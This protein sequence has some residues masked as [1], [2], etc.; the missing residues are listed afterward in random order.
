MD[1]LKSLYPLVRDIISRE[2]PDYWPGLR[3]VLYGL[4]G[5]PMIPEAILPLASCKAVNGEAKEAV[6]ISAAIVAAATCLRIFDDVE[7]KDRPGKL[8]CDVGPARAWNYAS[9]MQILSFNILSKAPLTPEVFHKVNRCFIDTFLHITCGQERDLSGNTRTIKDYWL[10][11]EWKIACGYATACAVGAMVGTINAELIQACRSFGHHL[12]IAIQILNDMQ[13]IW[14]SDGITDLKQGKVTLP[15]LYGLSIDHPERDELNFLMTTSE[16]STHGE[17][18]KDILDHL[19]TRSF[20][21]WA[22]LMERDQAIKAISICPNPDG[23]EALEAYITGIFGEMDL[24]LPQNS[25]AV[26]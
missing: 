22:A 5:E 3:D 24:L 23:R 11:I 1:W 10:T 6:Y 4:A 2:S 16:V 15:L 14:C 18:I 12:G 9:A 8:W 13:S 19:D 26:P 25:L 20:L 21:I 7:D 17:R